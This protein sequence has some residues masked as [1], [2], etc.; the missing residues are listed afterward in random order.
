M[1]KNEL[2]TSISEKCGMTKVDCEKVIDA[3]AE[4]VIESLM[5]GDK[6]MIKEFM[7]FEVLNRNERK[8]RDPKTG[9]VIS[10][11]SSRTVKC[12]VSQKIKDAVNER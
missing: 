7:S 12:K 8:G 5:D 2:I 9:K 3:F 11:P 4:S 1:G 6:V 10:Y